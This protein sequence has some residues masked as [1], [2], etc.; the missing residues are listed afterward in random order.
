MG[1]RGVPHKPYNLTFLLVLVFMSGSILLR[2][3][4]A[5]AKM[6][7]FT[8]IKLQ[9]LNKITARTSTFI[10]DV[11]NTVQFGP[12]FI[13]I[14]ACRKAPPIE[15]PESV[16]FLQIWQKSPKKKP[17][18]V[19]SGWMFASSPALSPMDH[20]IYDVWVLDCLGDR[21]ETLNPADVEIEMMP[22]NEDT[23]NGDNETS[24][25]SG[26]NLT[27]TENI[28][29]LRSGS[30]AIEYG[31]AAEDVL[32]NH[33]RT[34]TPPEGGPEIEVEILEDPF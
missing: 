33:G 14:Q 21:I 29:D 20:P 17:E 12:L 31:P 23:Q 32:I 3:Q 11:G 15:N 8:K 28:I 22:G 18:W 25:S 4:A 1:S 7:E 27:E 24:L 10:A 5:H 13:R 9:T 6:D 19:F 34:Q 26:T 2:P 16:G 30:G